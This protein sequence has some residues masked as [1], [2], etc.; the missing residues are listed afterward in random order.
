MVK[1]YTAKNGARYIKLANGQ[2][3]FVSGASRTYLNRIRKM[4]GGHKGPCA[5]SKKGRCAKSKAAG[6]GC[7]VSPA[8]RCR[9][10]SGAA[11][12]GA[13]AR[14]AAPAPV[15]RAPAPVRRAPAPARRAPAPVRR[16]APTEADALAAIDRALEAASGRVYNNLFGDTAN[17]AFMLTM[18]DVRAIRGG[19]SLRVIP[20]QEYGYA[21]DLR[22]GDDEL[23]LSVFMPSVYPK[24]L[25]VTGS[26]GDRTLKVNRALYNALGL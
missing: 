22:R 11:A 4:R 26:G 6:A 12:A 1:V 17:S 15:R 10:V 23:P 8:G 2:C 3:R 20:P 13:G 24:G 16:A 21:I 7:E 25:A 18:S 14:R 5:L 9:R 19:A